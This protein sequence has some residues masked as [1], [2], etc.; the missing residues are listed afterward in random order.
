ME[1]FLRYNCKTFIFSILNILLKFIISILKDIVVYSLLI[2]LAYRIIIKIKFAYCCL[3][4][5]MD[6]KSKKIVVQQVTTVSEQSSICKITQPQK[7]IETPLQSID[8]NQAL[9][10]VRRRTNN[11]S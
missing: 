3:S 2:F 5:L 4:D 1:S 11:S 10:L 7:H 6:Y 8:N 9:S